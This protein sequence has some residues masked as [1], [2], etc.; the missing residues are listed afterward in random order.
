LP[1]KPYVNSQA[2]VWFSKC[3]QL[4]VFVSMEIV[5]LSGNRAYWRWLPSNRGPTV[6]YVTSG[7]CLPKRCL[8]DGHI[9]SQ[10]VIYCV[11]TTD[12]PIIIC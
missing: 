12:I 9:P 6:D 5:V 8:A 7:M 1:R 11:V 10:Y 2:T 4:S 3:L